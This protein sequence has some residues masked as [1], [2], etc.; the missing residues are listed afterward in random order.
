MQIHEFAG[1]F[2]Q[3]YKI[4]NQE[5]V[6][7]FWK[8]IAI[9][10]VTSA[11]VP[12]T[13]CDDDSELGPKDKANY[14]ANFVY[15]DKP[16]S[17]YAEVEYKAN[18][19]FLSGLTDPLK[20]VPIRLTKPAPAKIKVKAVIDETLVD[21]YNKAKGTDYA[22]LEGAT[23]ENPT[24]TIAAGQYMSA[25]TLLISFG[26]H[27]GF[28]NQEKDLILP[29]V[30]EGGEGLTQSKSG[31]LFLTF[32]STYRPNYLT[33]P[34]QEMM[35]KVVIMNEGWEETIKTIN[36]NNAFQLS[37]NPYEEV[38]VNLAIDESKVA[39]Y[40]EAN[41][42]DYVFKSDAKL[43]SNSLTIGTE[44][45]WGSFAIETGDTEGIANEI[46]YIIPVT[47]NSADGAA[48]EL[49]ENK[50]VYVI[51][52]GVGRELIIS[53]NEYS[54]SQLDHPITCT[55]DGNDTYNGYYKWINVINNDT[56]DYGYLKANAL[57]EID[58]G[59]EVNLSSFYIYHWSSNY[60]ATSMTLE[61]SVDGSKW[62]DWGE[63]SYAKR[64]SYYV[65]LSAP[66]N[67]RYMRIKFTSGGNGSYGIEV[68]GMAFFGNK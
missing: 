13:A 8:Y 27:S 21:E 19:D 31:R 4:K 67:V 37:Y 16:S 23:I 7:K 56:W 46:A 20:L 25:D 33:I 51:I 61:T 24:M 10:A 55:V 43:V 28:I 29:I 41:G 38:T 68:D 2:F 64:S 57:M 35:N 39:A 63:V 58:F 22:F 30:V 52:K 26:D 54:G 44:A 49:T 18:G 47:I 17:T 53:P 65:N 6:K 3:M 1:F 40:N 36:V 9:A 60:S 59:K 12:F 45:N 15:F 62:V 42:T 32:T 11:M 5:I 66:E 48:V 14:E 50:T 34:T